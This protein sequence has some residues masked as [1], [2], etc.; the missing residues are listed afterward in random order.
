MKITEET[1]GTILF[2]LPN[3]KSICN[4]KNIFPTNFNGSQKSKR[5]FKKI[6][7]IQKKKKCLTIFNSHCIISF[8][9]LEFLFINICS[10][11]GTKDKT[12]V[13]L[14]LLQMCSNWRVKSIPK[15]GMV[16]DMEVKFRHFGSH[17]IVVSL[18]KC[19]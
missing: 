5:F 3:L 14:T 17:C 7:P 11:K 4:Y 16:G 6:S 9:G 10:H 15:C 18:K 19:E 13:I 2:Q 12:R 1:R 8:K